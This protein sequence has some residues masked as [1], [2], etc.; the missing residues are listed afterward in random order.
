[1]TF[2]DE[3][4]K[5]ANKMAQA[6]MKKSSELFEIGKL[7]MA[8]N[9]AEM[10]LNELYQQIG[11]IVYAQKVKNMTDSPQIISLIKEIT[12]QINKMKEIETQINAVKGIK[13]CPRC[14]TEVTPYDKVCPNCLSPQPD[15]V[16]WRL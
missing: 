12:T 4:Q 11:Q 1:M 16:D 9:G 5:T 13:I 8:L 7:K 15:T 6:T 2:M 10:D 14:M 3:V